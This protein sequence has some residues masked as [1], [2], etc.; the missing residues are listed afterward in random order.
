VGDAKKW[1]AEYMGVQE[2]QLVKDAEGYSLI[3]TCMRFW[4][5][6]FCHHALAVMSKSAKFPLVKDDLVQM[7]LEYVND[8]EAHRAR[9]KGPTASA[10]KGGLVRQQDDIESIGTSELR[11]I[12]KE[13]GLK[14]AK[15]AER[16]TILMKLGMELVHDTRAIQST[17]SG[18]GSTSR[19][20]AGAAAGAG[21]SPATPSASSSGA[22]A[23]AGTPQATRRRSGLNDT[24]PQLVAH[25]DQG[26][27]GAS[28]RGTRRGQLPPE[29][30]PSDD[31]S[32]VWN[33]FSDFMRSAA[34]RTGRACADGHG[35]FEWCVVC[36]PK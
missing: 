7:H 26:R 34:A 13:K 11:R 28:R 3:C 5:T 32:G 23:A 36:Q 4:S 19:L 16:K 21:T 24:H 17:S 18:G 31:N 15:H 20:G 1:R 8:K 35:V 12:A 27:G 10:A 29:H 2:V 25:R 33:P 30:Q 9:R 14:I 22:G 6:A